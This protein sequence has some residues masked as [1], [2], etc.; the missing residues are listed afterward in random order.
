MKKS[1]YVFVVAALATSCSDNVGT[2]GTE[3]KT[4]V[5]P[6]GSKESGSSSSDAAAMGVDVDTI[7]MA[8]FLA[9]KAAQTARERRSDGIQ[10]NDIHGDIN[11][12][13]VGFAD[14][15][16]MKAETAR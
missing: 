2:A 8:E 12:D 14:F 1:F 5:T 4:T 13:T 6:A 7:G 10:S 3:S 15:K 16:R 11:V 9:L